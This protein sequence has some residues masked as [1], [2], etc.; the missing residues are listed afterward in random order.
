[1]N[2]KSQWLAALVVIIVFSAPESD[3]VLSRLK[4]GTREALYRPTRIALNT[5]GTVAVADI[6]RKCIVFYDEQ[7]RLVSNIGV[8]SA[9]LSLVFGANGSLLVGIENDVLVLNRDGIETDRFSAHG[10]APRSPVGMAVAGDGSIYAIDK[11]Q[12]CIY[13]F[14]ASGDLQK[15]FGSSGGGIGQLR[16]PSGIAID[17]PAAEVVVADAGNSRVQVF[18]LSGEFLRTFGAHVQQADSMYAAVGRFARMQG[19]AV[20]AQHRVYV[21]DSGLDHVQLFDVCGASLGFIGKDGHPSTHLRVPMGVVVRDST[22][23]I[24]S[25]AGSEIQMRVL[26][27]NATADGP[28]PV[29]LTFSLEQCYPNPFNPTTSIRFT[30]PE[31][32]LVVLKVYDMMGREVRTLANGRFTSGVHSVR[33]DGRNEAGIASASG[34]YL[35]RITVG[36]AVSATNKMILLK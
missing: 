27:S 11:E 3:A 28:S 2:R 14:S 15:T 34:I 20:D 16:H 7:L 13:I 33:W 19:I 22:L 25:M 29:P 8:A 6:Q 24:A 35:Y 9:P 18:S 36:T 32:D 21:A 30:L 26:T 12:N 31:E 17:V 1:M 5:A 23:Y 10:M 4:G